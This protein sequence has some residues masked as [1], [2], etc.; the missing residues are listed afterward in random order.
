[1]KKLEREIKNNPR[2]VASQFGVIQYGMS[3]EEL[4][5][6]LSQEVKRF[7]SFS[8]KER[9][10]LMTA[11]QD[12]KY[13]IKED[14]LQYL[15]DQELVQHLN[16][17]PQFLERTAKNKQI[18][19]DWIALHIKHMKNYSF[20]L[21]PLDTSHCENILEGHL[22]TGQS[23]SPSILNKNTIH[24]NEDEETGQTR[25]PSIKL[26][27]NQ[28]K[29][30]I[31]NNEKTTETEEEVV[32]ISFMLEDGKYL[33]FFED[34]LVDSINVTETENGQEIVFYNPSQIGPRFFSYQQFCDLQDK[35]AILIENEQFQY[36]NVLEQL[37]TFKDVFSAQN[38]YIHRY[39]IVYDMLSSTDRILS[40]KYFVY[41]FFLSQYLRWWKGPNT[42][43]IYKWKETHSDKENDFRSQ[44]IVEIL[45]EFNNIIDKLSIEGKTFIT[46]LKWIDY[47][48]NNG[49]FK[50]G[51][52][53]ITDL[54]A[55]IRTGN[56]C[57]A[58]A[59]DRFASTGVAYVT[60]LIL[61]LSLD[62]LPTTTMYEKFSNQVNLVIICRNESGG[63]NIVQ[64]PLLFQFIPINNQHFEP[65]HH[66]DPQ[67]K[68]KYE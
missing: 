49:G 58:D 9:K 48:L 6:K 7:H 52:E 12:K 10:N 27:T 40:L 8:K 57:I 47:D 45:N 55:L 13:I 29:E 51:N 44:M 11:L 56:F 24:V 15:K 53:L 46:N 59:S 34:E 61:G 39:K 35:L 54:C 20:T 37:N 26:N 5:E 65:S 30:E 22:L 32:F 28:A 18:N 60:Y 50:I 36:I 43:W 42:P 16:I 33:S 23:R 41:L 68:K 17:D 67:V 21:L 25:S 62:D 66:T 31:M 19:Y 3:L 4:K 38:K 14:D 2:V 63:K 1:M 64:K